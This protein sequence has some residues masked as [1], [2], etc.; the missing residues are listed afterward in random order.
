MKP[1]SLK[2]QI[3]FLREIEK[4]KSVLRAN[5]T[6]DGRQENSAEHS[7]NVALMA[8]ILEEHAQSQL[9]LLR[10]TKLLLI[11]D[12][13][14]IDAGDTWLY[15]PNQ[16]SKLADEATAAN[17]LFSLLPNEQKREY[18]GLWKEFENRSTEEA[19][20]AAVID[21]IQPLLNHIVTGNISDGIIPTEKVRAKKEYIKEFAPNLWS[22]VE[23]LIGE[24]EAIGL[25]A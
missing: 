6:V 24:S 1:N 10:V 14:E 16:D 12:I 15:N 2:N 21:G 4:L 7:W 8:L 17:R 13:V 19:K 23:E 9:D 3:T 11:H 18:L 5:K 25:Y 20:F 22:L